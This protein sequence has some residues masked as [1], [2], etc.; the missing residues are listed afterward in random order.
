MAFSHCLSEVALWKRQ[1]ATEGAYVVEFLGGRL[2][3]DLTRECRSF[4]TYT[5]LKRKERVPLWDVVLVEPFSHLM[6]CF[7]PGRICSL[8]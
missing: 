2:A 5:L 3:P 4:G 1:R 6:A 7:I 8:T